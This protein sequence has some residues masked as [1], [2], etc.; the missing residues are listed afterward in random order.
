MS[1]DV[2]R[3]V[4]LRSTASSSMVRPTTS[5]SAGWTTSSTSASLTTCTLWASDRPRVA[6]GP[7]STP[8]TTSPTRVS[9]ADTDCKIPINRCNP[10]DTR[11][12]RAAHP[13]A[14]LSATSWINIQLPSW[15][16]HGTLS[17][18]I[19]ARNCNKMANCNFV[20]LQGTPSWSS[21]CRTG[22]D[23]TRTSCTPTSGWTGRSIATRCT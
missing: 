7:V 22:R 17:V 23:T 16:L 19:F 6:T 5:S 1:R 12:A 8:S 20:R 3:F 14:V 21:T 13:R 9:D 10:E 2:D 15:R 4:V 11:L 18:S